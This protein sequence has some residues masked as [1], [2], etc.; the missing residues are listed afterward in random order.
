MKMPLA[1]AWLTLFLPHPAA[2]AARLVWGNEHA[3]MVCHEFLPPS[4]IYRRRPGC[5]GWI[6]RAGNKVWMAYNDL[7]LR[8]RNYGGRPAQGTMRV[9]FIGGSLITAPGLPEEDTPPRAFERDLRRRG[10]AV[11]VINAS[12][13]GYTSWQNAARLQEFLDAYSPQF[14]VYHL[15]AHYVFTDRVVWNDLRHIE[16]EIVGRKTLLEFLPPPLSLFFSRMRYPLFLARNY[17]EQWGRIGISWKLAAIADPKDKLDDL[18]GPTLRELEQMRRLCR[19]AGARLYVVYDGAEVNADQYPLVKTVLWIARFAQWVCVR[20]FRFE[21]SVVESRLRGE[22]ARSGFEVLSLSGE[23]AALTEPANTL[24]G[25]YHWNA[26]G[27]R[28][29]GEAAAREFLLAQ[30]RG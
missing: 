19:S 27:A 17:R 8:D 22:D 15:S 20:N 18:M 14:V 2:A 9:L 3:T 10:L 6:Q 5:S 23:L 1:A 21:G 12:G 25:D 11:E 7:G 28:I 26:R 24:P 30:K 4:L 13:E 16:G 29:F